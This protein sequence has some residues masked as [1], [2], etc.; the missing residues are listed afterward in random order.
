[1]QESRKLQGHPCVGPP[2]REV[3]KVDSSREAEEETRAEL[4][5]EMKIAHISPG[6][7]GMLCGSCIH[8][9]TLAKA[10]IRQGYDATLIPIYT[11]IRTDEANVSIDRV[12][13]GAVNAYL[14][15]ASP[16]FRHMPRLVDWLLDRPR[17]LSYV[18][19]IGAAR[20][21]HALGPMTLSLIQGEHGPQRK[22][23]EKLVAWLRDELRPDVVHLT[24]SL[25]LGFAHRIKQELGGVP[26]VCELQGED[27]FFNDIAEPY[28]TRILAVMRAAAGDVD[29]FMAPNNYYVELMHRECG[30]PTDR[31][32]VVPLGID[33]SGFRP[34]DERG[35]DEVV[36]GFFAR[37]SPEKGLHHLVDA[38]R[39]LA[40]EVGRERLRLRAGGYLKELDRPYLEEQRR[41]LAEWGLA[42]RFEYVGEV[43][44]Q[45]K[46]DFMAGLDVFALPTVYKDPKGLSVL[47]A[48][49]SAVPAVVPAH[50]GFPE[51]LDSTGGGVLVEPESPR[52]LAVALRRLIDDPDGRR[53]LG[54]LG[55]EG[56]LARR[57]D[58]AMARATA[59]LYER[60]L[61][62]ENERTEKL[63]VAG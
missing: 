54:R 41:R 13:Y 28:R 2:I 40:A 27:I 22:E 60:V 21:G 57:T 43:D 30:F 39:I 25:F 53:N 48:L 12:F 17:L 51:L 62:P 20:E 32:E 56:V 16:V 4:R 33:A 36:I 34:R 15:H 61:Q 7:A 10:L 63:A 31:V 29:A 49:A 1:M 44:H 42:D 9:N 55:R 24:L 58:D 46:I 23:L 59:E 19:K 11:P 18:S 5:T 45:G 38:F 50:G 3:S 52:A 8:N 35:D 6:A 37:V 26:I 14:Q 47:E